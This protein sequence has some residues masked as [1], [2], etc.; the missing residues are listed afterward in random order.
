LIES[1]TGAGRITEDAILGGRLRLH[2]PEEGHRA[3]SD[4]ILLAAAAPAS[5]AGPVLDI[6]A[7]VGAAGLSLAMLRPGTRVGLVENDPRLAALARHN[8]RSNG[9]D[10]AAVYEADVLDPASRRDAGLADLSAALVISNPPFLDPSRVRLSPQAGKRTAHVMPAG[11]TLDSWIFACLALLRE[12]GQFIMIHRADALPAILAALDRRAGEIGL[13]PVYPQLGKPAVRII[14][15][16][17]K[18]S[19]G[20]FAIAPPL[21]LHEEGR[22]TQ[23][24]EALHRGEAL[25]AW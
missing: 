15:R 9:V 2:Q 6:G 25:I 1:A 20:P 22:F 4:A 3:G 23:M 7:G 14:L 17:K 18:G 10:S 11:V 21:I 13:L 5:V 16:A 12:G 24:A 8:L 19:R